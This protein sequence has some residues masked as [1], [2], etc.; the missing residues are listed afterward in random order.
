[1]C[2]RDISGRPGTPARVRDEM[3]GYL[4][5]LLIELFGGEG[6]AFRSSVNFRNRLG[7]EE[8]AKGNKSV[9]QEFGGVFYNSI[10]L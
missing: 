6:D 7:G 3:L 10:I 9:N 1:M 8:A 5:V 2:A 4:R